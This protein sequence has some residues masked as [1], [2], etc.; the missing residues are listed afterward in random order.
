MYDSFN[1]GKQWLD[2]AGKPIQAHGA[3]VFYENSGYYWIG[4]NKEFTDGK[5]K[6]IWTWGIRMYASRDLYNWEDR[7]L[8]VEPDVKNKKSVLHPSRKMDRPHLIYNGKTKKYVLWLKYFDQKC[9]YTVLT[10]DRIEGPYAIVRERLRPFGRKAGDYDLAV[11]EA[12]GQGYLYCE[13]DHTD[14]VAVKLN[15]DYT[16]IQGEP[17]YIYRNLK[18]PLSREGV[19][20]LRHGGKHYILT[21]GMMGYIPNPSEVAV[22]DD[23]MTGYTVQGNPHVNDSSRASFNSQISGVFPV[24]NSDLLVAV[25]D[26]WVPEFVMDAQRYDWIYRAIRSNYDRRV[27]ATLR[28]KIALT[29]TPMVGSANT[30]IA[31][32]VWLPITFEG[33]RLKIFWHDSWR[34]EDSQ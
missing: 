12:T 33:D 11:D 31:R 6:K 34:L 19:T 5:N 26:R 30:S 7:G 24:A 15:D 32:Y 14:V 2:T 10:A 8:I 16:D 3:C 25:A 27:K 28:E 1:P 23:W 21:S 4:E 17:S 18:P 20:H 29:K 9:H 13:L 22:S